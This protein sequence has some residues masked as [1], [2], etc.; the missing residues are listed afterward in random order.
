MRFLNYRREAMRSVG[1]SRRRAP[2]PFRSANVNVQ[3]LP[4]LPENEYFYSF[5]GAP[6][7]SVENAERGIAVNYAHRVSLAP[8][9]D[10]VNASLRKTER[11]GQFCAT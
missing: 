7:R 2:A 11:Y 1:Q 8:L 10:P 3:A 9:W 5:F 6:E 4:A